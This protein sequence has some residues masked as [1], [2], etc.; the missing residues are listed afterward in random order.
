MEIVEHA[1]QMGFSAKSTNVSYYAIK[2]NSKFLVFFSIFFIIQWKN[3]FSWL[4]VTSRFWLWVLLSQWG[5]WQW[6]T[7][8]LWQVL[9]HP[10]TQQ[11]CSELPSHDPNQKACQHSRPACRQGPAG[12]FKWWRGKQPWSHHV[13]DGNYSPDTI[14]Q[15][16]SE[17]HAVH[18]WPHSHPAPHCASQ[19]P[20]SARFSR[21]CQPIPASRGQWG[22]SV[23]WRRI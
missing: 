4:T 2:P 13:R 10:A 8:R 22:V 6:R 14:L 9:H 12:N 17:T 15:N 19:D 21:V 16:W 3:R 5:C 18:I 11:Y 20:N 7:G 1:V 23:R